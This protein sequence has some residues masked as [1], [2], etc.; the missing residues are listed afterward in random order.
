VNA[1][2][3]RLAGKT[4]PV[5]GDEQGLLAEQSEWDCQKFCVSSHVD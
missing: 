5:A 3:D 1:I 4:R 2:A